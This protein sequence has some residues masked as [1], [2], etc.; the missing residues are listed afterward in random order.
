MSGA[1]S[2]GTKVARPVTASSSSST[3]HVHPSNLASASSSTVSLHSISS[4]RTVNHN[5]SVNSP[6]NIHTGGTGGNAH[7]AAL[8]G[9]TLAFANLGKAK[10]TPPVPNKNRLL[11]NSSA[12]VNRNSGTG[13]NKHN[14]KD[15]ALA[16][17]AKAG[18]GVPYGGVGAVGSRTRS[19]SKASVMD[20][21]MGYVRQILGNERTGGSET[22]DGGSIAG[23]D[24][25]GSRGVYRQTQQRSNGYLQSMFSSG[26]S[27]PEPVLSA[28]NSSVALM[29]AN[30]AAKRSKDNSPHHTGQSQGMGVGMGI[31]GGKQASPFPSTRQSYVGLPDNGERRLDLSNIPHTRSL[32]GMWE[33]TGLTT[34]GV[35]K[36]IMNSQEKQKK[37][38]ASSHVPIPTLRSAI[39]ER[40]A[41]SHAPT[42]EQTSSTK[43][44]LAQPQPPSSQAPVSEKRVSTLKTPVQLRSVSSQSPGNKTEKSP[45]KLPAQKPIIHNP[46][47]VSSHSPLPGLFKKP[48]IQKLPRPVSEHG[49][50]PTKPSTKPSI[51]SLRPLSSHTLGFT[52]SSSKTSAQKPSV[53]PPRRTSANPAP[54]KSSTEVAM[55]APQPRSIH[56]PILKSIELTDSSLKRPPQPPRRASTIKTSAQPSKPAT[57]SQRSL[58]KQSYNNEEDED[59]SS[60]DSFVSAF[61]Q[62]TP[63]SPS[64][65]AKLAQQN[66]R[67]TSSISH[68]NVDS[69]A[70]A[71]V[72]GSLASSRVSSPSLP[73]S[74]SPVPPPPRRHKSLNIFHSDNSR[75]P[76]PPQAGG[77]YGVPMMKT[78]MRKPKT[79]KELKEEEGEFE[80]RRAKK[81]HLVKKHPNKHHEGDRKRWRD[82]V[83]ERERKRYEAVW[84]SNR[85]LFPYTINERGQKA[86]IQG[87]VG[88][89]PGIV[90]KDLWERSRLGSDVLEEVWMLVEGRGKGIPGGFGRLGKEE[91]V[92][93]LWLIDQRLKGRKLPGR[94]SDSVWRSVLGLGGIKIRDRIK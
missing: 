84:A 2:D 33:Q 29:A 41:S 72:A 31:K 65:R 87:A 10:V 93:G 38:P 45:P 30:L 22:T 26:T 88:S 44:P 53:P 34:G 62:P 80:R 85:G 90:V 14:G 40:P 59:S 57:S 8:T 89:V 79:D 28:K 49:P 36:G 77:T 15:E 19:S 83:T 5:P 58:P 55:Q 16:A 24:Y 70:N 17:A 12:D 92:A 73:E 54:D 46:R 23:S 69:L 13:A 27:T 6:R 47:P 94:V 20:E 35:E 68:M 4:Q 67:K 50:P 11:L 61:S 1:T 52:E 60:N 66:R 18:V 75:T 56:T 91:F 51:Q 21:R 76:T 9:A 81:H 7:N 74:R 63:K 82:G 48:S 78:T 64:W 3:H 71:I 25:Q 37:R 39:S 43:K 42:S 86:E 32:V